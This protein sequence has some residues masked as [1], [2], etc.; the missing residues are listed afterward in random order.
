MSLQKKPR[1]LIV[2]DDARFC[3]LLSRFLGDQDFDVSTVGN[4]QRMDRERHHAHFNL[5]I[6]DLNMPDED[7]LSLC[8]RL[9]ASGDRVPIIMLT[10]RAAEID[11]ITGLELGADDYLPKTASAQ[12]LVARIRAV[13][14][15]SDFLE[16]EV[17]KDVINITFGQFVLDSAQRKLMWQGRA[18][19]LT[20]EEFNLMLV[21]AKRAGQPFS[22][23]QLAE[24]LKGHGL[25]PDQ[26]GIDMLVSR[27]RK[28]IE[29]NPKSPEF[30]Q[31][32]RGFGYVLAL[33][34][35][36]TGDS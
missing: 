15:R 33:S 7:G 18:I 22:R 28:K 32:V 27:L 25:F 26:R 29:L 4:G 8:R 13:L 35:A 9:R 19:K 24:A 34:L 17:G 20:S 6:L 2:D 5:L 3:E 21:L 12:E 10:D 11:R 23:S 16:P 30:I 14:R 36:S 31:T 1:I